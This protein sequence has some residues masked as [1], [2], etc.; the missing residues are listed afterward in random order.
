MHR[1]TRHARERMCER[2]ISEHDVEWA[3]SHALAAPDVGA[4]PGRITIVGPAPGFG[5][6]IR[7]VL[8]AADPHLVITVFA[9]D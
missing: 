2:G 1:Y 3:C 7:V 9:T 6:R 5:G 8:D 4:K